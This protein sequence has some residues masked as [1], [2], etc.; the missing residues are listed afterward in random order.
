MSSIGPPRR[1]FVPVNN[2]P[3]YQSRGFSAHYRCLV[4]QPACNRGQRA[5]QGQGR[6][7]AGQL[8]GEGLGNGRAVVLRFAQE[9]SDDPYRLI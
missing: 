4:R 6:V 7:G 5:S 8:P 1:S 3:T 2:H 9:G